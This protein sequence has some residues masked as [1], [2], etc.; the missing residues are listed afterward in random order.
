[1]G[2]GLQSRLARLSRMDR[3]ELRTRVSQELAKH[4]DLGLFRLG[5]L[6]REVRTREYFGRAPVFLC[7]A[8]EAEKRAQ[9][10]QATLPLEAE[11]ILKEAD[12]ICHHRFRL[13]GYEGLDYGP[14]IDWHIDR[15]HDKRAPLK[16]WFKIPFL[17]FAQVGDHKI[18]WELNRHQHLV[19]LAKA[20]LLSKDDRYARELMA[21]WYSW[22]RANPYPLG[23]NWGSS[24]EVAFRSL[25]W[26][27]IDHLLPETATTT[28]FRRDLTRALGFH[29][30]Y[31]GRFLSTYFS[32]NTHLLGEAVALFFLG[33]LYPSI[34]LADRWRAEAWN[35]ITYEARRQVRPDG[36]YFEQSLHYHV[37][38]LDFFLYARG[39]AAR[40]GMEIPGEFDDTLNQMLDVV[41]SL[42]QA[43]PAEGFGDDDGGRVFDPR[44]NQTEHMTDPLA[45]GRLTYG[46][47]DLD[48]ARLTEESIWLFGDAAVTRLSKDAVQ[49]DE[50]RSSAFR[51]GGLYVMTGS[52]PFAHELVMDAGPQ[53]IGRCGHGHADALSI[54]LTGAGRRWLIDPGSGV[55]IGEDQAVR[56]AFRGTAA[57][58][59]LR[60]DAVDQATPQDPF[61]WTDIPTTSVDRWICGQSF[62]YFAGSHDGYQRL[63]QPATHRRMVLAVPEGPTLVRDVVEGSGEHELEVNWHFAPDLHVEQRDHAVVAVAPESPERTFELELQLLFAQG[64]GWRHEV[65]EGEHSPAYGCVQPAPVLRSRTRAQLPAETGSILQFAAGARNSSL[66]RRLTATPQ[67]DVQTYRFEEGDCVHTFMFSTAARALHGRP[68]QDRSPQAPSQQ[69]SLWQAGPWSSDA[70][71]LYSLFERSHLT[72]LIL[73]GGTFVRYRQDCVLG[74]AEPME[75]FEWR[76][77]HGETWSGSSHASVPPFKESSVLLNGVELGGREPA[78]CAEKR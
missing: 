29:G 15:V 54:R 58:N 37:Y 77:Q 46:R 73:I 67:T 40:N 9:L 7:P 28:Q 20:F 61:S 53:G 1:M 17:D 30:R 34:A 64:S 27:W 24:L 60:V 48:S 62:R 18:I 68:L 36:V 23:I 56:N 11:A 32:P 39:L 71:V 52:K 76:K 55:Y 45:L 14:E 75:W 19:T 2:F 42:S 10:L 59:T 38:A 31:V 22:E 57:H 4:T 6:R 41:Q 63:P 50:L 13:L 65:V 26:I 49:K 72:H 5:L 25:S 33:T 74:P 51:D 12:E 43:G 3:H 78:A 16:P 69:D 47:K 35:I 66:P 70:E 44:R 21:Q 8:G